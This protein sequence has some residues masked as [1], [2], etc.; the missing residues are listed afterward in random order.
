LKRVELAVDELRHKMS[1][2]SREIVVSCLTFIRGA[3][4]RIVKRTGKGVK[5]GAQ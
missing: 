4:R 1:R 3:H 2:N 5:I